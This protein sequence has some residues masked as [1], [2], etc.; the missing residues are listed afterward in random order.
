MLEIKIGNQLKLYRELQKYSLEEVSE[1]TGVSIPSLSNI[2]RGN[3]SPSIN[4]LWKISK[5]LS[6]P[7]SYFFAE[8]EVGYE[9]QKINNLKSIDSENDLVKIFTAFTWNPADNFEV[10]F[11]ELESEARRFS[12]AH[13]Y[14]TVEIIIPLEGNFSIMLQSEEIELSKETILRFDAAID[15]E[16]INSS[17]QSCKFLCIMIYTTSGGK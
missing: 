8:N 11:L 16:Y 4:T 5:G 17:K 14:G 1:L 2:E 9:I 6:L 7:I 15:H 12:K 10:L 3:T 13:S